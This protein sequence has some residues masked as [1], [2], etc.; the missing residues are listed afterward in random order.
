MRELNEHLDDVI[1]PRLGPI[2]FIFP[3]TTGRHHVTQL[4][5]MRSLLLS[6]LLLLLSSL[7]FAEIVRSD[8]EVIPVPVF[9][10][11]PLEYEYDSLAPYISEATM[12]LHHNVLHRTYTANLNAILARSATALSHKEPPTT[13]SSTP[14]KTADEKTW[15]NERLMHHKQARKAWI[16]LATQTRAV[17][18][19]SEDEKMHWLLYVLRGKSQAL[20]P[21][22]EMKAFVNQA[23]GYVE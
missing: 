22:E 9:T 11:P 7:L 3:Q 23:G 20:M 18:E 15:E 13:A 10:L 12:K 14:T 4:N 19:G 2:H 17:V 5:N 1:L 21:M 8:E 6:L 16:E